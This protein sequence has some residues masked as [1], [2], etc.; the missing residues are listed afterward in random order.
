MTGY[1]YLLC[2]EE[3][4]ACKLIIFVLGVLERDFVGLGYETKCADRMEITFMK[5]ISTSWAT[6]L[7][8]IHAELYS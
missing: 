4:L 1:S 3:N 2:S 5:R 8:F 6:V 7:L